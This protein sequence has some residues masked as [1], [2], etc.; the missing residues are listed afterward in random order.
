[1][2]KNKIVCVCVCVCAC[3]CV[4]G[5]VRVCNMHC[6]H[7]IKSI[8]L[9]ACQDFALQHLDDLQCVFTTFNHAMSGIPNDSGK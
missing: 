1:M 8:C 9:A 4:C 6:T 5:W 3:V 7:L 2:V